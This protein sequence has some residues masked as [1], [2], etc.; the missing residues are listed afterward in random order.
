MTERKSTQNS[1]L[2]KPQ[3][4]WRVQVWTGIV[5]FVREPGPTPRRLRP[6]SIAMIAMKAP[7]D[8][9][10]LEIRSLRGPNRW[11]YMPVLEVLIDIG[12]LEQYPSNKLP[13]FSDR[14]RNW[15]PGLIEHRC[16]YEERGGFLRRLEEGTWP[17]HILEHVSLELQ[18]MAGLPSGYGRARET[19]TE[20]VY[21]VVVQ[22][23][24]EE[25]A[26]F[27]VIEGRELMM[28]AI[29]N[30]PYDIAETAA[31]LRRMV[32]TLWLGPSTGCIVEAADYR[33]IPFIRLNEGNLVQLGYGSMQR[34]IWTAETTRTSAI[35]E[36]I[37]RDKDLTKQL[38]APVGIPVPEGEFVRSAAQ[39][40]EAAEAI[41]YPVVV[42]PYDGNHGRGVFTNLLSGE[43]VEA[44]YTAA[45]EQGSGVIVER[46]IQGY[47]HR[48]LVVAGKLVAAARG[49]LAF[50]T[51]DGIHS[52]QELIDTQL[53]ENPSRSSNEDAPLNL[54]RLDTAARLE[55]ARQGLDADSVLSDGQRVLIQRNGNVAIDCT[56]E[57]HPSTAD[58]VSLAARTVG[59][60]I[61]GIDLVA[62][63]ISR[64][65]AEQGGAVVEVNA[66]PGL[67]MHLRPAEGK[68]RP[69]G[70]AIVD[71]LFPSGESGRIPIIGI[72]GSHGTAE[73]S[74]LITHLM[75]SSGRRVGS[76]TAHG[77]VA[78]TR[79]V[80][81]GPSA[82]WDSAHKVLLN[83]SIELAV[84]ENGARSI[85]QDGLAYDRCMVGVVTSLDTQALLPDLRIDTTKRL[86]GVLRTQVDVVLR[87]GASILNADDP[88]VVEMAELS[89]GQVIFYGRDPSNTALI[90]HLGHGR[91][92]VFA[93]GRDI[94][95]AIG[96]E[97]AVLETLL[98]GVNVE[99]V[100]PAVAVAWSLGFTPELIRAGIASLDSV[101][102]VAQR[103]RAQPAL[104]ESTL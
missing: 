45:L 14:L 16:S 103:A 94:V 69:V 38:L 52:V 47:E 55:L 28:A 17:G 6:D 20:G 39:A 79:V 63:D 48:L 46:F 2:R 76:A 93:R 89:D 72:T 18:T 50:V 34:R 24:H 84:I 23:W 85:A 102:R 83:R 75:R 8:I 80:Q 61:A 73:V 87:E 95:L 11:A 65:L 71:H 96:R 25:I 10:I 53:N 62:Q 82:D 22:A 5:R 57:V 4:D 31:T 88:Q 43:E 99:A 37:S 9:R 90:D 32:D 77:L 21:E 92:A 51:G 36:G 44:A 64:P 40:R 13:G 97:E 3:A 86:F 26:R 104:V 68:A 35:A 12:E 98:D 66:G 59:L 91:R 81:P 49:D 41:G 30:R 74:R 7:G 70:Q 67:L 42:K 60:D 1:S 54:V 56:D 100:L 78:D 29:E 101:N 19:D 15:L 27:A 58:L 33:G